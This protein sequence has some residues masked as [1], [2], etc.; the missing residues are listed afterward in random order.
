MY[1][2]SSEYYEWD[3]DE[4]SLSHY[5]VLGMK[6]GH[7]KPKL[8]PIGKNRK[9][10]QNKSQT[11]EKPISVEEARKIASSTSDPRVVLKY[12]HM[13]N[14]NEL[15]EYTR[16]LQSMNQLGQMQP[17]SKAKKV[18]EGIAAG[19]A[20]VGTVAAAGK[21]LGLD[22]GEVGKKIGKG[23]KNYY[24][25]VAEAAKRGDW[26]TAKSAEARKTKEANRKTAMNT[27]D[28]ETLDRLKSYLNADELSKR[29]ETINKY[30]SMMDAAKR[31]K[32][33]N[34]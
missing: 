2:I 25:D 26:D 5:G 13:F 12:A 19:T 4:N 18:L 10:N 16:R 22:V 27:L 15:N 33:N 29:I 9:K 8:I 28:P 24:S 1:L 3:E 20:A 21:V 6:W 30:T 31:R 7:R 17:K 32:N 14:A 23:V 34:G 11:K